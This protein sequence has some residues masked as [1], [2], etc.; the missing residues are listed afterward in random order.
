MTDH[1]PLLLNLAD[2]RAA[3][4]A[5]AGHKASRLAAMAAAGHPVPPGFVLTTDACRDMLG[6]ADRTPAAN[7][8][9]E[10]HAA[11]ATLGGPVAVRSSGC[12]EDLDGA[13]FAGLYETVLDV[14]DA[15]GL[16]AAIRT[17]LDSADSPRV[18]AYIGNDPTRTEDFAILVQRMVP[19]RAAGVAFTAHP[20]TG[21]RGVTTVSAVAG[22]G[23][24]LVGGLVGAEEWEVR[25]E[26]RRCRG[27]ES[28]LTPQEAQRVAEL[29]LRVGGGEPVDIEWAITGE[30]E[31]A[32]LHL[33]QARP[34][35]ALPEPVRWESPVP[36]HFVRNLR[37]GEWLGTPVTPLFESWAL[38]DIEERMLAL[39]RDFTGIDVMVPPHHVIVNGWYFSSLNAKMPAWGIVSALAQMLRNLPSRW[40]EYLILSPTWGHVAFPRELGRWRTGLLPQWRATVADAE[41]AV[42]T[43]GPAQ[44]V[45]LVQS[46]LDG[47]A[48]QM[49]AILHLAGFASKAEWALKSF[50]RA[51][52]PGHDVA[53]VDLVVGAVHEPATHDVEGLD[54]FLPTLGER[55]P[56][57]PPVPES[58]RARALARRDVALAAALAALPAKRR[59][60][61]NALVDQ[62]CEAHAARV[63]QTGLLT[64]GWPVARRALARLG[65]HLVGEQ[66]LDQ[67]DQVYFLTRTELGLLLQSGKSP[68]GLDT[69][70]GDWERQR[71]LAPPLELG[72][73]AGLAS[74][75]YGALMNAFRHSEQDEAGVM[76]GMSA[77]AG[78]VTGVARV[79]RSVDELDRVQDGEILV[80]PVT[81]PLWTI[82]FGR[83]AAVVTDSGSLASHASVVAREYGIPAVV[84]TGNATA[85]IVDGQR[86][87]VD[88]SR[89]LVRLG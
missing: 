23:E 54:W 69:R 60:K 49:N 5:R 24:R 25:E 17:C 14:G 51:H 11:F 62:A 40:P 48:T 71:R 19:A 80:A 65:A 86:I 89:G 30:G 55:G 74:E 41:G 79:V 44:L 29:A 3:E 64:L 16:Q 73:A 67:A 70:R 20:V 33:L 61:L 36:G 26:V 66:R 58:C 4:P 87:T 85:R 72:V 82:A 18:R 50:L 83:I 15:A 43:A 57:P 21:E 38:T 81:T 77:S 88:G 1:Q 2:P 13:S 22:T 39:S 46:I 12:A 42:D 53:V 32:E 34:M 10:V 56:V 37:L 84:G 63:D 47:V 35:T 52:L 31:A 75:G 59:A 9:V 8:L 6:R 27:L 78:R 76:A 7:L 68:I 28:V 45:A